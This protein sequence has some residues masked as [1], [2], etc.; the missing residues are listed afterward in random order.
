MN[1]Q[2]KAERKVFPLSSERAQELGGLWG[3]VGA[4]QRPHFKETRKNFTTS[5]APNEAAPD[6]RS[7]S[8]PTAMVRSCALMIK[9]SQAFQGK[10]ESSLN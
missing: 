5:E 2:V 6:V 1:S 4:W 10:I 7:L 9:I 3:G 8:L